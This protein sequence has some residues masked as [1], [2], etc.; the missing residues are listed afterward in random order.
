MSNKITKQLSLSELESFAKEIARKLKI[1]HVLCLYGDL[2]AGKT[3]I[4]SKIINSLLKAP[5]DVTSP[6]FNLVHT[7]ETSKGMLWHFDMYRLKKENEAYELGIEDAFAYG[8]SI[9]EWPENVE[10]LLPKS[11]RINIELK[12]TDIE[13]QRIVTVEYL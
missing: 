10:S 8:I 12:H 4:A 5:Q 9:I 2:G 6:T 1:S 11:D 7:Y 3:T 13:D